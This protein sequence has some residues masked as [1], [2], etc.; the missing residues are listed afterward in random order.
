MTKL[1]S[2]QKLAYAAIVHH[3]REI[4]LVGRADLGFWRDALASEQLAPYDDAGYTQMQVSVTDL[5]WMGIHFNEFT[6]TVRVDPPLG[7]NTAQ[8]TYLACAFNSSKLLALAEQRLF[9]TPYS[10]AQIT[11]DAQL[12]ASFRL[13]DGEV[14]VFEARMAAA[15]G[16]TAADALSDGPVYL[17][18]PE[19]SSPS[20][21]Y[22]RREGAQETARFTPADI[23]T[24]RPWVEHPALAA[25]IAS[26]FTPVEWRIA[27]NATH[28]RSRTYIRSQ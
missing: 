9:H 7:Q 13:S 27:H 12:P 19:G 23:L 8:A 25:L 18:T 22:A 26:E 1:P 24:M 21:F 10:P 14:T 28:R 6:I 2:G 11:M 5:R 4:T 17:P 20:L 15:S 16:S 3:V